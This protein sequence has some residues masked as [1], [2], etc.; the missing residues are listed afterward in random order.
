MLAR[1]FL[2]GMIMRIFIIVCISLVVPLG[3]A[4]AD[5]SVSQ[6]EGGVNG[7]NSAE[8]VVDGGN[9]PLSDRLPPVLPGQEVQLGGKKMKVWSSSGPVAVSEAPKAPVVDSN[10]VDVELGSVGVVVDRRQ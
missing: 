3:Q 4:W 8:S 10:Q 6:K 9:Q 2:Q 1:L 7:Q 5:G